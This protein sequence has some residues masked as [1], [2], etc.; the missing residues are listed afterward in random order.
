MTSHGTMLLTLSGRVN[1]QFS[2]FVYTLCRCLN[3]LRLALDVL[4][5]RNNRC[6]VHKHELTRTHTCVY[7]YVHHTYITYTSHIY[8]PHITHTHYAYTSYIH[9][10]HSHH[11]FTS[12]IHITHT[13]SHTY[14]LPHTPTPPHTPQTPYILPYC[15]IYPAATA[16]CCSI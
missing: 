6:V 8:T 5:W 13:Q 12:H 15:P 7:I 3:S 11:T 9:V 10:T 4:Y 1:N 16:A 14:T 2:M